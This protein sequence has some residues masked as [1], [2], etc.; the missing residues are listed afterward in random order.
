MPS[1]ANRGSYSAWGRR[2]ALVTEPTW[3]DIRGMGNWL[4]HAYDRID[5][6]TIWNTVTFRL[7][8]LKADLERLL[9]S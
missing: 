6:K 7:P 1:A 8:S 9:K 3:A 4:R 2:S 5:A